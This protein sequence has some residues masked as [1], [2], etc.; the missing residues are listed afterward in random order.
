VPKLPESGYVRVKLKQG[1]MDQAEEAGVPRKFVAQV[2]EPEIIDSSVTLTVKGK[3][4]VTVERNAIEEA[5]PIDTSFTGKAREVVKNFFYASAVTVAV[6]A[7][8][9]TGAT[10]PVALTGGEGFWAVFEAIGWLLVA[11]FIMI[12]VTTVGAIATYLAARAGKAVH[13]NAVLHRNLARATG[14]SLFVA[15]AL[16]ANNV[17]PYSHGGAPLPE[18]VAYSVSETWSPTLSLPYGLTVLGGVLSFAVCLL[19]LAGGLDTSEAREETEKLKSEKETR[20][21]PDEEPDE[22]EGEEEERAEAALSD[23]R[24]ENVSDDDLIDALDVVAARLYGFRDEQEKK[25]AEQSLAE[26]LE[27]GENAGEATDLVTEQLKNERKEQEEEEEEQEESQGLQGGQGEEEQEEEEEESQGLQGGQGEEE[28]DEALL[29]RMLKTAV[30]RIGSLT[31]DERQIAEEAVT[32]Y[33]D[34]YPEKQVGGAV[35]NTVRLNRETKPEWREGDILEFLSRLQETGAND[36]EPGQKVFVLTR[37]GYSEDPDAPE[38]LYGYVKNTSTDLK[39]APMWNQDNPVEIPKNDVQTI[40]IDTEYEDIRPHLQDA[41]NRAKKLLGGFWSEEEEQAAWKYVQNLVHEGKDPEEAGDTVEKRIRTEREKTPEKEKKSVKAG[42]DEDDQEA[43]E[44]EEPREPGTH[45]AEEQEREMRMQ[46]W[47]GELTNLDTEL[48]LSWDTPSLGFHDLG[49]YSDVVESLRDKV[50]MPLRALRGD[51]G[52]IDHAVRAE[53]ILGKPLRPENVLLHG[54]PGTGKTRVA[55]ALAGECSAPFIE[56]SVAD[57][58]SKWI[59]AGPQIIKA[60]FLKAWIKAEE[61]GAAIVFIDEAEQMLQTRGG[62]NQHAEDS[63]VVGE[64]L[65][66]MTL[67]DD[68]EKP[69][70]VV[71]VGATNRFQDVDD[72]IARSGRFGLDLEMGLPD[73]GMRE[74]I[75]KVALRDT[76]HVLSDGDIEELAY[77]TEGKTGAD[78]AS[79]VNQAGTNAVKDREAEALKRK[80]FTELR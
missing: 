67:H 38:A 3:G 30:Y 79:T 54:P 6:A 53:Q 36:A 45:D 1:A 72:G 5:S 66:N 2:P 73:R 42:G 33:V 59:N 29:H 49:G 37:P 64:F 43:E 32:R 65:K 28:I 35:A 27:K 10:A 21:E 24:K 44:Q 70:N 14:G 18:A 74:E 50:M 7:A 76:K 23:S 15:A 57:L 77:E 71:F 31:A 69:P 78:I 13:Q 68:A 39:I 80:H 41:M 61:E 40:E 20:E 12:A 9:I 63:K 47:K 51:E 48:S 22:K 17:F 55:R 75:F 4:E 19:L 58:K 25:D 26:L 11:A 46:R 34:D 52:Y 56:L 62:I 8:L 16:A 60:L